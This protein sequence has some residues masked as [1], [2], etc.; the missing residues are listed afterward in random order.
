MVARRSRGEPIQYVLGHWPFRTLDL[1]V[2]R[3]VLIPRP[4]TEQVV[5]VALAEV[6]RSASAGPVVVDL[7]TGSGAIG[8]AVAV[9]RV[10]TAVWLTELD[11]DAMSVARAN[12]AGVGRAATRVRIA[13]GSWFDPLP[14][15]LRG[16]IDVVVSNPPYVAE[17]DE[18]DAVVGEWEP[19]R[20]LWAADDGLAEVR[21]IVAEAVEWLVP[22]G[23]LVVEI[24]SAQGE[25]ARDLAVDAGYDDVEVLPDLSGRDRVL[26]ARRRDGSR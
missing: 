9:E 6:D 15:E 16:A 23:S 22:G 12:L 20:A 24:G 10:R 1:A 18:V 4:E 5:E 17:G 19:A 13:E 8:L 21:R 3:R 14:P 26:R 7:G 11:P 2:D 25:R